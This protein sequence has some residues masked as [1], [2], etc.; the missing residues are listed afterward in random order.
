MKI[1]IKK[2]A[3]LMLSLLLA[4][5]QDAPSA[6]APEPFAF[7]SSASRAINVDVGRINIIEEYQSPLRQPYMEQYFPVPPALAV[8]KWVAHRLRATGSSGVL[9][10][11]I[12]DA[13]VKQTDL[14]KTQGITGLFT[15]DQDARYDARIAVTI[16]L[17]TGRQAIS[18]ATTDINVTRWRSVHEKATVF[19][20]EQ[21]Y[22]R[23]TQ[24]MLSTFDEQASQ[25]L[26]QY[27]SAFLK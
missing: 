4:A 20:R 6:Y 21:I 16:R 3:M 1:H 18:D 17:F 26:R 14:P 27:F 2:P 8:K 22:H 12:S 10:I 11:V 23:M 24:D 15:D 25:R 13:S 9:E 19:E 5:C 7:E